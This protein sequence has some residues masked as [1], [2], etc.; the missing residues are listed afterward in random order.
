M[1]PS[2]PTFDRLLHGLVRVQNVGLDQLEH[3]RP[4][5]ELHVQR[6]RQ[7]GLLELSLLLHQGRVHI[8]GVLEDVL[9]HQLLAVG[10][11]LDLGLEQVARLGP[12]QPLALLV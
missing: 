11:A 7:P 2:S 9:P 5:R 1:R 10:P 8:S 4:V 3:A 12:L 6:V